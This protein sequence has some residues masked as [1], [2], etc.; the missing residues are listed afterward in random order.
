VSDGPRS[1]IPNEDKLVKDLRKEVESMID[2]SVNI[3]KDYAEENLG[4]GK[5]V[6]TGIEK[7]LDS[8]GRAIIV[9]DDCLPS[10]SFFSYCE[11]M[12]NRYENDER[13]VSISGTNFLPRPNYEETIGF[14]HFPCI[15]G[16][17]TWK[18]AWDGYDRELIEWNDDFLSDIYSEG[19]LESFN[20]P[21]WKELFSWIKNNPESTWDVQFWFLSLKKRGLT[22]FPYKNQI[23]NIGALPEAT[24][25][26]RWWFCNRP[27]IEL[28]QDDI[29]FPK[30]VTIDER[31]DKYLQDEFYSNKITFRNIYYRV[32]TKLQKL[33]V[34][35]GLS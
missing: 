31:Y 2:W 14:T 35:Y 20:L 24:H 23:K 13:I 15:W 16:W 7:T 6:S 26:T 17:A 25:T 27:T 21:S 30:E 32:I 4:C 29:K 1:H 9:E 10:L 19:K 8:F 5:R 33:K 18:R 34:K 3:Q 28:T 12:L 22:I 11:T